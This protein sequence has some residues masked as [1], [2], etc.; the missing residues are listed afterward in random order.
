MTA[1]KKTIFGKVLRGAGK[2]GKFAAPIVLGAV[3]GGAGAVALKAAG[4]AGIFKKAGTKLANIY[5]K[6]V[7]KGTV[8]GNAL[9]EAKVAAS[10]SAG[11]VIG[12]QA[13][14]IVDEFSNQEP[15]SDVQKGFQKGLEDG[16]KKS[17][18]QQNI[19]LVVSVLLGLAVLLFAAFKQKKVR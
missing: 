12:S 13:H 3:T 6:R 15:K 9:Q 17:W 2:L 18:I 5:K 16:A 14:A 11:E 7:G 8:L 1:F 10:E 19:V 4:K